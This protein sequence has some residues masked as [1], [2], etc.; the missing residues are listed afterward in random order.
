MAVLSVLLFGSTSEYNIWKV[1]S[2]EGV[3][4]M[5]GTG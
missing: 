5:R 1:V 2:S 3:L 4:K